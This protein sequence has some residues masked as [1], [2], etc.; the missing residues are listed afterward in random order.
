MSSNIAKRKSKSVKKLHHHHRM[1]T[2]RK[3]KKKRKDIEA[4][5]SPSD[6]DDYE[7]DSRGNNY[8]YQD[9]MAK[10]ILAYQLKRDDEK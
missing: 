2:K 3:K 1:K 7:D 9:K 6:E 10:D 8:T 5:W 4:Y